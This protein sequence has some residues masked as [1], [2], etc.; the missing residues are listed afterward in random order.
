MTSGQQGTGYWI[1][2]STYRARIVSIKIGPTELSL[3]A[4]DPLRDL[5][6]VAYLDAT[7]ESIVKRLRCVVRDVQAAR[8]SRLSG[9]VPRRPRGA[10]MAAD[11]ESGPGVDWRCHRHRRPIDWSCQVSRRC[12]PRDGRGRHNT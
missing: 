11:V 8:R 5:I 12:W 7:E 4:Q 10:Q 9:L 1:L 3:C 2:H 6:I